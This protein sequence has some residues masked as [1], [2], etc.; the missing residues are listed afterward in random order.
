MNISG[1]NHI[2][3]IVKDLDTSRKFYCDILGFTEVPRP[4]SFEF[5]GAWFVKGNAEIHLV[6]EDAA[7]QPPGDTPAQPTPDKDIARARHHAFTVDDQAALLEHLRKH[8]IE[9][10]LGPRNRSD[11][12]MQTYVFDPDMHLVEFVAYPPDYTK[13]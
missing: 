11:G 6:R 5:P 13:R 1:M 10:V 2:S 3:I 12:V 8:N 9:I 4:P 7:S